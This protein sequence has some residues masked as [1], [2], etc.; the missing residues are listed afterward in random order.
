MYSCLKHVQPF[1]SAFIHDSYWGGGALYY[2]SFIAS[3]LKKKKKNE[4]HQLKRKNISLLNYTLPAKNKRRSCIFKIKQ[5]TLL[6]QI[7]IMVSMDGEVPQKSQVHRH[8][9]V[10]EQ[11]TCS[12]TVLWSILHFSSAG[13][14]Q[15]PA[16]MIWPL[17]SQLLWNV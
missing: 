17:H 16:G 7:Q 8:N 5:T 6:Q 11:R 14:E 1:S 10:L 9:R 3:I 15:I 4:N 13:T 2:C 12:C